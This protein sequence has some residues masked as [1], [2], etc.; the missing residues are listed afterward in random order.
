MVRSKD[1]DKVMA[2]L[3]KYSIDFTD[4]RT[5]A[6]EENDALSLTPS[7]SRPVTSSYTIA[8]YHISVTTRW[9]SITIS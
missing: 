6:G 3:G 8:C 5:P 7:L 2:G 4:D 9:S 1:A